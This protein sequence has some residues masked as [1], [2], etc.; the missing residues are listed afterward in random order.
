MNF[1]Q[2]VLDQTQLPILT[3]FILGLMTAISPCPLATNITAMGYIAK[4]IQSKRLV[5]INGLIYIL[6]RAFSYT[7]LGVILYF[8]ASE[9]G[10]SYFFQVWGGRIIGPLILIIGVLMLDLI[11]IR[12]PSLGGLA[13]QFEQGDFHNRWR[14][15]FM[16]VVFALAFCPYSGVLYF[17]MLIPLSIASSVGL[18]L[19][20]I[21]AIGTGLPVILFA[22]IL[23]Y[24]IGGVGKAYKRMQSFELWFRRIIAILFIVIGLYYTIKMFIR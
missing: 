8:S 22:W 2:Q 10:L 7:T 20:L 1:L 13:K 17:G 14:I 11:P 4:D 3:A 12:F 23:A 24:T 16:G 18:S 15:F 21:F 19:P 6:G 9:L 5:F